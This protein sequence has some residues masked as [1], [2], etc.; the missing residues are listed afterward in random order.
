MEEFYRF[1]APPDGRGIPGTPNNERPSPP[2]RSLGSGFIIEE[3]GYILTNHHVVDGAA[4]IIVRMSDRSE[5]S[6]KLIG[7]DQRSDLAVLKIDADSNC[8]S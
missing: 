1:F 3:D 5:Y 4:E 7:S 2:R 8:P 6:A